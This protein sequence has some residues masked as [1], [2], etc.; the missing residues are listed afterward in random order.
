[1]LDVIITCLLVFFGLFSLSYK[2]VESKNDEQNLLYNE[3]HKN[4]INEIKIGDQIWMAENLDSDTFMNG[5]T[6]FEAATQEEWSYASSNQ[7]PAF[8][9]YENVKDKN[10]PY[11]KLYNWHAVI[12][13]RG[14]APAGWHV[15]TI[16]DWDHLIHYLGLQP[17]NKL[18]SKEEWIGNNRSDN[19]SG[20]SAL[21]GGWRVLNGS[22]M[23]K[24]YAGLWWTSTK[25]MEDHDMAW[26]VGMSKDQSGLSKFTEY[27]DFFLSVRCVK[28]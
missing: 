6:I 13:P 27:Y 26:R 3:T 2:S 23:V 17:A 21:P 5:D 4:R 7:I 19:S 16:D 9:Y 10:F 24:K 1:M 8:C 25:S 14:L 12:D 11:G 18:K 22:F 28:N 20:F 15:A